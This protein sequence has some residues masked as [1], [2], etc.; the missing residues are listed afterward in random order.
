MDRIHASADID[1]Y[2][3][4]LTALEDKELYAAVMIFTRMT[5]LQT[6]RMQE[7]YLLDFKE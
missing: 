6:E 4:D 7:S 5:S 2:T 3:N 1:L